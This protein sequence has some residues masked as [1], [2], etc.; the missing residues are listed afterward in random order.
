MMK[1]RTPFRWRTTPPAWRYAWPWLIA[2]ALAG[3]S[4]TTTS[5]A[6]PGAKES[7][8]NSDRPPKQVDRK[9]PI[10][11]IETTLGAITVRLD[12]ENA[13]GTVRNF[14]NYVNEGFYKDTIVHFVDRDKTIMAGGYTADHRLKSA[15]S[16]IRNEAHNG[17]KNVRGT[18]AMARDPALIDSANSQFF[19]NLQDAPQRDHSGESAETYGYCV[20]GEVTDGLDVAER[21][22]RTATTDLSHMS[23][24]L[25]ATPK[26][27][28]VIKSIQIVM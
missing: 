25:S 9:H 22:S 8:S 7:P 12:A 11:R 16:P 26:T 10:V 27:P 18:I 23:G 5:T 17:R 24:D 21:I 15:R 1:S 19:I 20:F 13:P 3:C 6:T 2:A 4:G 14:L 28:V